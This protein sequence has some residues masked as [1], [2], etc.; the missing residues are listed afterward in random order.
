[1]IG[2]SEP[3]QLFLVGT[4]CA[5]KDSSTAKADTLTVGIPR[6]AFVKG[7]QGIALAKAA[8]YRQDGLQPSVISNASR[9]TA[10]NAP[11]TCATR[12]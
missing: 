3:K 10:M 11:S 6:K 5:L 4:T 12:R 2:A 9:S 7:K 1:M 8:M